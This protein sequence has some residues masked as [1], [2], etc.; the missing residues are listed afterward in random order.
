[1]CRWSEGEIGL[2][3]AK[4]SGLYTKKYKFYNCEVDKRLK[5]DE[6]V[7]IANS[8]L[9]IIETPGHSKG[10]I[11]V[12]CNLPEGKVLFTGDSIFADGKIFVLN[13]ESSELSDY[14]QYING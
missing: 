7:N 10:S 4:R 1:M 8:E 5:N 3:I 14:R 6:K 12:L 9:K 13:H 2:N 11:C